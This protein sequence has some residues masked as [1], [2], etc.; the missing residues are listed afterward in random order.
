MSSECRHWIGPEG[1]HCRAVDGTRFYLT[2][3]CCPSHTPR[4]LQGLKEIEP[5]PGLPAGAW[6]TPSPLNDSRVHDNQ[7]IA[8]GKRRSTPA[9]YRAAQAAVDHR[10]D[11]NL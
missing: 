4:A 7:A 2:G 6:T 10:K 9:N 1:R 11:L 5:G 8:S 3:W